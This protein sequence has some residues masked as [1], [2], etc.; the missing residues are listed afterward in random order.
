M[1]SEM[2][3]GHLNIKDVKVLHVVPG[4][5]S[6]SAMVFVRRQISGLVGIGVNAET[7][8]LRSRTSV[9]SLVTDAVSLRALLKTGAFQIIHAQF[10]TMTSFFT[11]LCARLPLVITFRGSDLNPCP[12]M[13]QFRWAAGHLMS[14]LSA[15]RAAAAICVSRQLCDRLWWSTGR[16]HIIP[17]GIDTTAFFPAAQCD[18]RRRLGWAPDTLTVLFNAGATP[19]GKRKDLALAAVDAARESFPG[20]R[21]V[22]LDGTVAPSQVPDY[23]NASDCLLF[24]SDWEGSPNIVKEAMACNL[25]VVSVDVGDVREL[26]GAVEGLV[27]ADRTPSA[28]GRALTSVLCRRQRSNGS[29]VVTKQL[30]TVRIAHRIAT[31]YEDVLA[32]I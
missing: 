3:P 14:Q 7:F 26:F 6:P 1:A 25:P 29:V 18:A 19:A 4:D 31:V 22:V 17:S 13:P 27:V 28:L 10:G 16:V 24:T 9:A 2:E 11:G 20:L 8:I 21:L 23:L 30:S 15:T 5:T 32:A 12:T